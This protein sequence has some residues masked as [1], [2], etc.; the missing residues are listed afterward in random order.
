MSSMMLQSALKTIIERVVSDI[1]LPSQEGDSKKV[2]VFKQH[3][4]RKIKSISRNPESTFYP[5][6]IVYLDE[7]KRGEVKILFIVATHDE[8]EGN[9]GYQDAMN[10]VEKIMQEFGKKPLVV[11]RYEMREEYD[12]FYNDQDNYPYFFAWIETVFEIP[13]IMREDVEVMI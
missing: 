3:L 9:Q 6:V 11:D 7:G 1:L 12:W 4:P 10:I 2:Q 13:R 5:C 8:G